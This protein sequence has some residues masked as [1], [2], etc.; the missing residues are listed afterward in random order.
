MSYDLPRPAGRLLLTPEDREA[1][2]RVRRLRRLGLG[3]HPEPA[4]DAFA[5]RLAECAGTPYAMVNFIDEHRQF[6]AGLHVPAIRPTVRLSADTEES[7]PEL[8][9]HLERDHG[10]CPHVVVRRKA[11]VLEDVRDYPRFA[12]NPIVDEFG[13]RS[14]LGAPLVD[15]TGM[16][17]GTVCVADIEPR[18][19]GRSGLETIKS[20]AAELVVRLERRED[21]GLLI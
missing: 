10:F 1:A 2:A 3:E 7:T 21:G 9:R 8:G 12:G 16:V 6:F 19:W 18:P 20:A 15:S 14:Y 13:I 17:L 4:L 11:L 5:A